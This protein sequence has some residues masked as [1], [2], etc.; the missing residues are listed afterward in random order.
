MAQQLGALAALTE[1]LSST[2]RSQLATVC[3]SN[4]RLSDTVTDIHTG[5][6]PMHVKQEETKYF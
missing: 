4:S 6:T 3:N 2:P 1:N 5:K